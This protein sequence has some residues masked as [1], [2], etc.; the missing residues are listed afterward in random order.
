[1][2]RRITLLIKDNEFEKIKGVPGPTKE[3]IRSIILYKSDVKSSDI[4]VDIGCGTGGISTEFSLHAKKVYSIDVKEDA[5]NVCRNNVSKL[6][7]ISKVEFVLNDGV[8]ALKIIDSFDLVIVGGS[9]GR[10][11]EILSLVDEKLNPNGRVIVPSILV[12]TCVDS[13]NIFKSLDYSV[14]LVNVNV[15]EAKILDR[16]IMMFAKNPISIVSAVK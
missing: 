13:V 9:N 16:G 8:D 5:M 12:D 7:D 2:A 15:S 14:E 10:L 11:D 3:E 6:G 1:M 4:V